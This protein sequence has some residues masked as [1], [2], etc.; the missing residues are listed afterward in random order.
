MFEIPSFDDLLSI[1]QICSNDL[2][3]TLLTLQFLI[4]SSSIKSLSNNILNENNSII[5][6]PQWQSSQIFDTMYYSYLN[7]S[8]NE[9]NLQR[10][11]DDLT[12]KY[13]NEYQQT[14]LILTNQNK[15]NAKR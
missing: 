6:K 9:S 7:K 4:Q 15:D 11:F 14:N 5:T 13:T 10:F 2:R 3:Q 1:F 8:S 12:E